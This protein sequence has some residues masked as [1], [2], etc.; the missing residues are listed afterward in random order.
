MVDDTLDI[1]PFW[2]WLPSAAL[3]WLLAVGFVAIVGGGFVLLLSILMHGPREGVRLFASR[4]VDA[5][6]DL[7]F[8]SPRRV[9]A[10]GRLTF[11][12]SI[13]RRVVIVFVIFCVLMLFGGWFLDPTS[14]HPARLY[15]SFVLSATCY[16]TVALALFLSVLSIPADIR[17]HTIQTVVTKPVRMSEIVLGRIVGFTAIGTLLLAL[18]GAASY[19]FVQRGVRHTHELA[20]EDVRA[21]KKAWAA[22][23]AE[24]KPC[25]PQTV[26]T[27]EV[28]HHR[29]TVTLVPG[30]DQS[31]KLVADSSTAQDHWHGVS[32]RVEGSPPSVSAEVGKQR[33]M[34]VARVPVYGT[35]RFK[36]REGKDAEKGIS[37]GDEWT[38]RSYIMGGSM[39]EAA[40]TFNVSP[41]EFPDGLPVEMNLGVFRT[42]KGDIEKGVPGS[43]AVRNPKTKLMSSPEIFASQEFTTM[44]MFI[45]R[46]LK[47]EGREVDLFQDL[48]DNGR[49][50]IVLMCVA[51]Q[52]YFGVAQRDLYLRAADA[53]FA[54]NF[55]KGYVGI[56]SQML[57]VTIL[58]VTFS[59]F[60][61]GPIAMLSMVGVLV[62]QVFKDLV[63]ELASHTIIG[64]GPV[65]SL[66]RLLTRMNMVSDLPEGAQTSLI[67]GIDYGLEEAIGAA[68]AII[69]DLS[70]FDFSASVANGFD[71]SAGD[72]MAKSLVRI[73]AYLIPVFVAGY[74]FLK[75]REV[76]Q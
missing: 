13:R 14:E 51:S 2:E 55:F 62:F 22:S 48:S 70:K 24:G 29:H 75:S 44:Q 46:K 76:A 27:T 67:K 59:T 20:E 5:V 18:M 6:S 42:H 49:V 37:V 41:E 23:I 33:G 53:S 10:L 58:G 61:S 4:L 40:W 11:Q 8:M 17:N 60:L 43:I 52:Q 66:F 31:Q 1:T 74:F 34:L 3:H 68:W 19:A 21:A 7:V 35:L 39:A 71:I 9:F 32:Y 57:L 15:L 50:E 56:W 38:Y 47:A 69:P 36:D 30:E 26:R 45:P 25:E 54:A 72:P 73:A 64:G 12:E 65:E 16:L 28:N 63:T